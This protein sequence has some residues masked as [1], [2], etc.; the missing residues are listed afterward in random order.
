MIKLYDYYRS[1]SSYR[2][3]IALRYKGLAFETVE[4][5]LLE[6]T[7]K[8]DE[9]AQLNPQKLVP[10]LVDRDFVL[11]QSPAIL[12]YLEEAYPQNP[13]L[14]EDIRARA[15][16]RQLSMIVGCEIHPLNNLRVWKGYV[17]GVLGADEAQ[18]RDWYAHWIMQGFAAY[19]ALLGGDGFSVGNAPSLADVYLIPQVYNARRFDVDLTVYPKIC[20]IEARCLEI[21]AFDKSAP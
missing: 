7:Q 5:D 8:N 20:A 15:K 4:V 13:L 16:V 17:G 19:E 11:T 18:M 2:V 12:E 14:P 1:S 10:T 9:Y 21:E 6:G 3:R